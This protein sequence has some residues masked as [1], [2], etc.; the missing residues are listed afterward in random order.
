LPDAARRSKSHW[1]VALGLTLSV[2]CSPAS[3]RPIVSAIELR[4]TDG[5]RA[6]DDGSV[7]AGLATYDEY[8]RNVLSRDLARVERYYRAR[9]YYEAKVIASRV[10]Q[11]DARHVRIE[12]RVTPGK[13]VL[14]RAVNREGDTNLPLAVNVELGKARDLLEAGAPF[15][16]AHFDDMKAATLD[17][18]RD[19][20]YPYAK[21]DAKAHV[22]LVTH[23]ADVD[24]Q[25]T[26]G[27]RAK[28]GEVQIIGLHSIPE[29]PVR[30]NLEVTIKK[31]ER[32]SRA[33]LAEARRSLLNQGVFAS[34]DIH[35]DLSHPEQ[36]QVPIQVI[37]HEGSLR[38]VRLGGGATFDVVHLNFHLTASWEHLNFLGGMRDLKITATPGVDLYPTRLDSNAQIKPTRALL[39][40]SIQVRLQQ[41]AFLEGRTTGTVSANYD[42]KPLL[43][44]FT[45]HDTPQND[46][47]VGYQSLTTRFSLT[48]DFP[49][50][51]S[52]KVHGNLEVTPAYNWQANFPFTYQQATPAGLVDVRVAFPSLDTVFDILDDRVNPHA[53]IRISNT[54]ELADKIFG[55]S[56]SDLKIKPELRG[57]IPITPK[58]VTLAGRV[59]FGFLFPRDYGDKLRTGAPNPTS[60]CTTAGA[61][62][63]ECADEE[64][65]VVTDQEK[66]LL[67]GFYSG[68]GNSNRGY[69]LRGVGP[70]GPVGF[71]FPT[72]VDCTAMP[73]P[74][75]CI[76]PLGGFTLWEASLELRFPIAGAFNA[77]AFADTSDVTRSVG[78]IR[79][80]VPHLSV[81]PGLRYMT[82]VGALRLDI[83][84]RVP[85]AQYLGHSSLP[86]DEGGGEISNLF[87]QS[88][89]PVALN[90]ALGE[91]F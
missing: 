9:G 31:G 26:P 18:L 70:Y 74:P 64:A 20:G 43:Y 3:T 7:L 53:G 87:N 76:R 55:G 88:W 71:L 67:R 2:A 36:D 41:P 85:G 57:Y 15:D 65:K 73:V 62:S 61:E 50:R 82:P 69:P 17:A 79:L 49:L 77:V 12:I 90:I 38:T 19:H 83:G 48:R 45:S 80:N 4:E 84:Y 47:I 44:P 11:I 68:G 54:V 5:A 66:L 78:N 75:A 29:A 60:A 27:I 28:Y 86:L 8:D 51:F 14:V 6:V 21:V 46:V 35:D 37:V 16:E 56:V 23:T 32:Y 10:L 42:I 34:V 30:D 13:P 63:A 24:I 22:D 39:E 89:L 58:T 72:G 33:D 1:L 52:R 81:G 40:N 91:A 59:D 25:I